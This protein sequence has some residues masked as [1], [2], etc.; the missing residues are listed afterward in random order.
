MIVKKKY[1]FYAAHRNEYLDDKCFN[2]HGHVYRFNVF[3]KGVQKQDGTTILFNDIDKV[4]G[5]VIEALD[6]SCLVHVNDDKLMKALHILGTK[7]YV[8]DYSTSAENIAM[9]IFNICRNN[10]LPIV[11]IELMETESSTVIY[12]N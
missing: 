9:A 1:H 12:E 4:V 11:K 8:F 7:K 6:H 3:V 10:G 2:L 5:Q